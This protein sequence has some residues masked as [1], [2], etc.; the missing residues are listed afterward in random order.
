MS[1]GV[2]KMAARYPQKRQPEEPRTIASDKVNL[3]VNELSALLD[4]GDKSSFHDDAGAVV[5][6]FPPPGR[7]TWTISR[8]WLACKLWLLDNL[9]PAHDSGAREKVGRTSCVRTQLI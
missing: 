3:S 8:I 1:M 6:L 4:A 9:K 5:L 7:T 2:E